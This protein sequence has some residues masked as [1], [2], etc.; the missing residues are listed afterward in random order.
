MNNNTKLSIMLVVTVALFMLAGVAI[1]KAS[2]DNGG[3]GSLTVRVLCAHNLFSKEM[4]LSNDLAPDES[5][6]V[7]L[8]PDGTFNDRYI[9]GK[10][11]LILLDGNGAHPETQQ[12]TIYEDQNTL[13]TFIG[14]AISTYE[15]PATNT[16]PV[17]HDERVWHPGFWTC[18][19]WH[20][21][22]I[23]VYH[24]GYWETIEVCE[25]AV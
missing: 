18:F 11:T 24:H 1:V 3:T 22:C 12:F 7:Y 23:P 8:L 15:P 10:Y 25:H 21:H 4:I 2:P 13:V 20:G 6:S 17:C 16:T 5:I 14:H 9:A 19:Y